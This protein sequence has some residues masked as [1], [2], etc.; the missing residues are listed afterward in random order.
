MSAVGQ[1]LRRI[2]QAQKDVRACSDGLQRAE[3]AVELPEP[4]ATIGLDN[5][6]FFDLSIGKRV[7]VSEHSQLGVPVYS[8]N[9]IEPFGRVA[10]SNLTDF[11]RPSLLWGIDGNFD[12]NF[13]PKGQ[14]FATTDHCGRLQIL[15]DDLD[16]EY[17]FW[18]LKLNRAR[19]GFDRVFRASLGNMKAE[20]SV[21]IPLDADKGRPSLERQ[22][23]FAEGFKSRETSRGL[24]LRSLEDVLASRI[25]V[26]A[27]L[28][29]PA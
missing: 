5:N 28:P 9:V 21:L 25:S 29:E 14:Q 2:E 11:T 4:C 17:V 10:E 20:V 26:E 23:A 13:I 3:F 1:K 7:L 12:W 27:W 19:Y 18:Y 16:P 15:N 8:A 24:S 6:N 22:R